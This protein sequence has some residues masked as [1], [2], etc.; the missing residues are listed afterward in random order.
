[1]NE[2]TVILAQKNPANQC[3]QYKPETDSH[4]YRNLAYD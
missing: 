3:N 2:S 4:M 1:M